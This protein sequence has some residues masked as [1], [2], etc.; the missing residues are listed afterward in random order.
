ML[1][2]GLVKRA[3]RNIFYKILSESTRILPAL[4]FIYIARK[5]GDENFGKLS[6]AYSF[7]GICFIAAD[8]GLST[9]LIRNVSRQ[10]ELTREYV[11]NILAL[12][13]V[14]SLICVSVIGIFILF[15]DYPADVIIILS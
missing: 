4:L 6:F 9:I 15:T 11:G 10:K 3:R 13:T 8:F 2:D 1:E 12:K 7:A 14:L 5:L